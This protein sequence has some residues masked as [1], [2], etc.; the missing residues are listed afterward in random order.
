ML[1]TTTGDTFT[2]SIPRTAASRL[3]LGIAL[4]VGAVAAFVAYANLPT[5]YPIRGVALGV[6]V[7]GSCGAL[8]YWIWCTIQCIKATS[9][10]GHETTHEALA[11]L[12]AQQHESTRQAAAI[13]AA[14]EQA[15][16]DHTEIVEQV[17]ALTTSIGVLRDCY[18]EEG[19]IQDAA[20]PA[21][22]PREL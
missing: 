3:L 19:R 13:L 2:I 6:G 4:G 20:P 7:V 10:A 15:H 18:L 9:E 11:G 21:G 17:D 16:R 14:L 5:G 1:P 12:V 8:T 22:P